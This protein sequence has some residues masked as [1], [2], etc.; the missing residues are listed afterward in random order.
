M[1][2]NTEVMEQ[3]MEVDGGTLMPLQ[4][5][6]EQHPGLEEL[7]EQPQDEEPAQTAQP[8]EPVNLPKRE[9]GWVRQRVDKA[10]EK[11]IRETE[12]RMRAEFEGTLA[13]IR[14]S[15]M[16]READK[17]VSSGEFKSRERAME[18]VRMKNGLPGTVQ[19]TEQTPQQAPQYQ[20]DAETK[21]RANMLV[22]QANKLKANHGIDVVAAY[23]SNEEIKQKVL[24]GEWDFYDVAEAMQDSGTVRRA[25][26]PNLVR[27]PG[28]SGLSGKFSINDM[29]DAQFEKL[30]Q[31][32]RA[33][34]VYDAR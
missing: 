29:S 25:R 32:L 34:K 13:P 11:A 16:E 4:E 33:G 8:E 5:T 12:A 27:T 19:Q 10:V 30:Q 6:E 14:E 17:L 3:G 20:P 31:N 24:S 21:A 2:E 1:D 7:L 23:N 22:Q 28:G 9:P 15:M 26:T 18:Y